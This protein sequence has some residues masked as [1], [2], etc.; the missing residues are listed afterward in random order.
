MNQLPEMLRELVD[1]VGLAATM[2]LVEAKG[3]QQVFIPNKVTPEHWLSQIVGFENAEI[4]SAYFTHE[5]G[6]HIILP[7]ADAFHRSKRLA[8]VAK[9]VDAGASSNA[10]AAAANITRRHVF[11]QKVALKGR[12]HNRQP[13]LFDALDK[14]EQDKG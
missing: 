14:D 3:G 1:L 6:I 4:I 9:M 7:K 5:V 11:R 2:R 8:L 12:L 13:S 10:I